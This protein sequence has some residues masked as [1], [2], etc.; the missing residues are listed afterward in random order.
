MTETSSRGFM[1]QPESKAQMIRKSGQ[2]ERYP[3]ADMQNAGDL[4]GERQR[5]RQYAAK[6]E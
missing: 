6:G 5:F 3:S 1:F 4:N 2:L